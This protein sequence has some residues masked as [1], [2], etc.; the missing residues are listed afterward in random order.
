MTEQ[1]TEIPIESAAVT[2]RGLNERRPLNEDAHLNDAARRIFAVADGVGGAEAGEVASQTAIEVLQQ[3]FEHHR[4]GDDAEDLMEIAIQRANA[5]IH[6]MSREHQKFSMMATTIVA[7]HLDGWQA[8]IGHVGDSRLYRLKP[9]G[10]LQRETDD[11]SVVEEEVRAGRMTAQQAANHPSR[12][13]ISRALGAEAAVEVDMKTI[14]FEDGTMFLLCSDGITRHIPDEELNEILRDSASLDDACAEMKRRCYERGAEDN[15]TAVLIRVGEGARARPAASGVEFDEEQ[16]LVVDRSSLS[17]STA[18]ARTSADGDTQQTLLNRPFNGAGPQAS[19]ATNPPAAPPPVTAPPVA[20]AE[21]T[22]Q[23]SPPAQASGERKGVGA[24]LLIGVLLLLSIASALAFYGGM[25]YQRRESEQS[26]AARPS[27]SATL[28]PAVAESDEASFERK[29]RVVDRSPAAEAARMLVETNN[30]PLNSEDPEF[31]YLYGRAMLLTGKNTEAISA[32]D[33]AI[34]KINEN[35]T[36]RNGQLKI[37]T[38]LATVTAH[39][40]SDNA[41]GARAAAQALDEVLRGAGAPG[42][43]N[44]QQTPGVSPF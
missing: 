13:I 7:I 14:E 22:V 29:R 27:P 3:A 5:S 33:R 32:F 6:Q 15:L 25:L 36:A 18:T 23:T 9:D 12:N 38:R 21:R 34:Q 28:P 10:R 1:A 44:E 39:V 11:H 30:Q 26:A 35:T 41:A 42:Q 31:L 24:G 43:A 16:T 2:D 8:T 19:F 37:D 17:S 4:D 20:E 40:R